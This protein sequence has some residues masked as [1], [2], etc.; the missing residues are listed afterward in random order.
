LLARIA[1]WP[2]LK[3]V[4]VCTH[5]ASAEVLDSK[6]TAEQM[7]H[8]RDLTDGLTG[9]L[10]RHAANSAAVFMVKDSHFDMV[11]PGLALYGIDPTGWPVM[12]R[13]LRPVAKW[14]APLVG[15]REIPRGTGVG[16]GHTWTAQRDSRIGL[17]PVGYADGYVRKVSN[18]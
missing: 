9:A 12:D 10:P 18:R 2:S 13:P 15:I 8:F 11:R 14:T 3:L 7:K 16:Y 1:S 5:F 6:V 17:V 4:G